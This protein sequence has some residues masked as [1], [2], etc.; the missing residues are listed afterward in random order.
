LDADHPENGVL[1]PCRF[2]DWSYTTA[3]VTFRE[4]GE[5]ADALKI[6]KHVP[7]YLLGKHKLPLRPSSYITMGGEDEAQEYVRS[8]GPAWR[9]TTGA[10]EWL[11]RNSP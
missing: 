7:L 6:N 4:G 2:T 5:T 1:I 11:E 9:R 3:L 8:C 10:L